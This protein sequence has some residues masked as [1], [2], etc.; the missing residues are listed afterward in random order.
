VTT[1]PPERTTATDVTRIEPNQPAE[2]GDDIRIWLDVRRHL[3]SHRPDLTRQAAGYYDSVPR[4]DGTTLLT[5][6]SWM[7]Q[8]GSPLPE[9]R[10]RF[11]STHEPAAILGSEKMSQAV[12]P[13]RADGSRYPAYSAA[14]R[15]LAAPAVFLDRPTY[16]LLDIVDRDHLSM[17]FGRGTYFDGID[18]GEAAA[19]EFTAAQ[20]GTFRGTP[21]RDAIGD[22]CDPRR[23]PVNV[24]ISTLTLRADYH[25]GTAE[26]F[27]HWR[28]PRKVGHAGGLYQVVPVGVFQASSDATWNERNDFDLWRCIIREMSEELLGQSEDHRSDRSPIDYANWPFA[29]Q[30]T[31]QLG[32]GVRAHYLGMGV[33]PLTLATDILTAVVIDAPLFDAL[34]GEMVS[35]NAE[36]RVLEALDLTDSNID[37]FV[38]DEP[39]QAAGAAVLAQA[40]KFRDELLN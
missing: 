15:D 3:V 29:R 20:L 10:L 4:V 21:L 14:M 32:A 16:R 37:R 11:E 2:A 35:A 28:D 7:A 27:V 36:G 1:R 39:T 18:V 31:E 17:T 6:P 19:H 24:A 9:V 30:L 13:L 25:A 40:W 38:H 26:F 34:L 22:P 12:R 23:R 5:T 8:A 33:D